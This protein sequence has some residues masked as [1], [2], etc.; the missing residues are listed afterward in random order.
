M[1]LVLQ[2]AKV[3]LHRLELL[4]FLLEL[5]DVTL[6]SLTE[7]SLF[8]GQHIWHTVIIGE[9]KNDLTC[10]ARFCAAR[11]LV[12]NSRFDLFRASASSLGVSLDMAL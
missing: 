3:G 8:E 1:I 12:D 6:L 11:L 9:V 2:A 10:A 5:C 7:C 4:D